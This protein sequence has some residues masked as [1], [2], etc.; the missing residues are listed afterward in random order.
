MAFTKE[1]KCERRRALQPAFPRPDGRGPSGCTW[2]KENG[3]WYRADG[4]KWSG[5]RNEKRTAQRAE[6]RQKKQQ[7]KQQQKDELVRARAQKEDAR[8]DEQERRRLEFD[9]R[10]ERLNL[11]ENYVED[12]LCASVY[13]EHL[14]CL[15]IGLDKNKLE[16]LL[17]EELMAVCQ[18]C[19]DNERRFIDACKWPRRGVKDCVVRHVFFEVR[20][21]HAPPDQATLASL[22][23][24]CAL[25]RTAA[26]RLCAGRGLRRRT[27]S[28]SCL[29]VRDREAAGSSR[30]SGAG[31][32]ARARTTR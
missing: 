14:C 9:S 12:E 27:T 4:T 1:Q 24:S 25:R 22:I 28:A 10:A 6:R 8:R 11:A 16:V 3:G 29:H 5:V 32:T 13:C 17:P 7:Q 19:G 18:E 15:G 21:P 2:D 31:T 26:S 20:P 23:A 30:P